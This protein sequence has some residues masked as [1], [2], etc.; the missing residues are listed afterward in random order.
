MAKASLYVQG[1][2][3]RFRMSRT[4]VELYTRCPRCFVLEVKH[5]L[6][7]PK[8]IPFTLN[9]AV[10]AQLKKEF[11]QYRSKQ[12]VPEIVRS[13]GLS[14]VPFAHPKMDV[15]RYNFKGVEASTE[16]FDLFGA[17]DDVWVNDSGELVV[18]DYKATG[19]KVAKVELPMGGFYDS[20]RRQMEFYQWLLRRNGFRV[21]AVGYFLYATATQRE[22]SFD[23]VLN[24]ESNLIPY[25]GDD[26]WIEPILLEIKSVL[27][28]DTLPPS[29]IECENCR[30]STQRV[31]ALE[32]LGEVD[33]M[34]PTCLDCGNLMSRA[35]Y[36]MTSGP[37]P[38]GFVSMGCIVMGDGSDPDWLCETCHSVT[39][40]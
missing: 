10:D 15:W 33:E 3:D 22:G 39:E 18:V 4:K 38:K 1:Q 20:Y 7:P 2:V 34:P 27:D 19:N 23:D 11:D 24:F 26:S 13:A 28:T 8:G 37:L 21:S 32:A 25:E 14:L 6:K 16:D 30:Y 12:V 31:E 9:S 5:G 40:D 35:V 36:G 17:V 29:G